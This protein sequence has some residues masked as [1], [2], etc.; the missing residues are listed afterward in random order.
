MHLSNVTDRSVYTQTKDTADMENVDIDSRNH[1]VC[2]RERQ[3]VNYMQA[4]QVVHD[5]NEK[6]MK[7]YSC[8]TNSTSYSTTDSVHSKQSTINSHVTPIQKNWSMA[9]GCENSDHR[10]SKLTHKSHKEQ[11]Q[12]L[13]D[14]GIVK[15]RTIVYNDGDPMCDQC[16]RRLETNELMK[17][18]TCIEKRRICWLCL[19]AHGEPFCHDCEGSEIEHIDNLLT[20]SSDSE[21]CENSNDSETSSDSEQS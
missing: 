12:Q 6:L 16:L 18:C 19:Y 1:D 21:Y 13:I 2:G 3:F 10:I 20:D 7:S 8:V 17:E 4:S 9:Q 5:N 11:S 15:W 14:E